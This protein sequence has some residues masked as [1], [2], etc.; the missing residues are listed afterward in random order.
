MV[1]RET[2][3]YSKWICSSSSNEDHPD[4]DDRI[5]SIS[6]I[7]LSPRPWAGEIID[8]KTEVYQSDTDTDDEKS[9]KK[10]HK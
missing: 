8:P 5:W 3:K 7:L 10:S 6:Q 4:Q 1:V 2:I 9:E